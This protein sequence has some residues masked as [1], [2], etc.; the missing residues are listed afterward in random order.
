MS[1]N[2]TWL[3]LVARGL[4]ALVF[5]VSGLGKIPGFEGTAAY[6]ANVGMPAPKLL[7][8]LAIAAEVGGPLLIL[9]GYQTRWAALALV[10]FT[11]VASLVFHPF[12]A[13]APEAKMLQQIMFMKNLSI[14][15]GLLLLVATGP[16]RLSL[17]ARRR[18]LAAA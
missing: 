12:W 8:P 11:V 18:A 7:L 4:I 2:D 5:L 6:M 15:G 14:V 13:V 3:P 17:D 1:N 16:G 9:V 10:A